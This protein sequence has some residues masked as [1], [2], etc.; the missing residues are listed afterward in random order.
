[1]MQDLRSHKTIIM[2]WKGSVAF[3]LSDLLRSNGKLL[4]LLCTNKNSI[5]YVAPNSGIV[6]FKINVVVWGE[7]LQLYI[8]KLFVSFFL[9]F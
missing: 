7:M 8:S 4:S 6:L 1:M 5:F 9:I 2:L 3:L